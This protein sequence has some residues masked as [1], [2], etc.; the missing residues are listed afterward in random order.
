MFR[1]VEQAQQVMEQKE[2]EAELKIQQDQ[3]S[4]KKKVSVK[5][6]PC[7]RSE[8]LRDLDHSISH[9]KT[10]RDALSKKPSEHCTD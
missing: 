10:L 3:Q 9:L 7:V 5:V 6:D 8:V 1:Q 2:K 4:A